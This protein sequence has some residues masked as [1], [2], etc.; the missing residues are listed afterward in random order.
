MRFARVPDDG[1]KSRL[2]RLAERAKEL[3]DMIQR[4][5]KI[6]KRIIE[7]IQKIGRSDRMKTQKF[8]PIP[9][10]RKRRRGNR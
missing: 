2:D 4:A 8:T 7:E 9:T 10:P 3:D 6:Q 5:A 1:S